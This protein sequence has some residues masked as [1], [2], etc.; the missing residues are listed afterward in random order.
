MVLKETACTAD[1]KAV[2]LAVS[3]Y[4]PTRARFQVRQWRDS[5]SK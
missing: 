2:E 4:S 1:G 5:Q 3:H